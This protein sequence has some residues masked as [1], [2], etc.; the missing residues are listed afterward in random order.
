[1]REHNHRRHPVP[2]QLRSRACELFVPRVKE[3]RLCSVCG[4]TLI[5]HKVEPITYHSSNSSI[6]GGGGGGSLRNHYN[7]IKPIG[8]QHSSSV[9]GSLIGQNNIKEYKLFGGLLIPQN[10]F[11][12]SN[13][14]GNS[15]VYA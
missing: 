2:Q 14:G 8:L 3:S 6:N 10:N 4:F 13:S 9:D 15:P 1:M 7:L 12:N 5:D 11:D